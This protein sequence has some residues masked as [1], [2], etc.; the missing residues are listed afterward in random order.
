MSAI[1]RG[2]LEERAAGIVLEGQSV[3]T[4]LPGYP[5]D[6]KLRQNRLRIVNKRAS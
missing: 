2:V 6:M 4:R 1:Q 3:S 5:F